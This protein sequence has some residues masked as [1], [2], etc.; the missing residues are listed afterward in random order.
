[1]PTVLRNMKHT[2][3]GK[4]C[5]CRS[6]T[7]TAPPH[8]VHDGHSVEEHEHAEEGPAVAEAGDQDVLHPALPLHL[9][10]VAG[11]N[12]ASDARGQRVQHDQ[13][14]EQRT[15]AAA[16]AAAAAEG[17]NR[18]QLCSTTSGCRHPNASGKCKRLQ[19]DRWTGACT[20]AALHTRHS[21][22]SSS[23]NTAPGHQAICQIAMPQSWHITCSIKKTVCE[24]LANLL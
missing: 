15:P 24:T 6:R 13:R 7:N 14:R 20:H 9:H 5:C 11:G 8:P 4:T 3:Q 10:V 21:T 18:Q 12:V 22:C 23:V 1:M 2:R 16:A 17:V 19:S